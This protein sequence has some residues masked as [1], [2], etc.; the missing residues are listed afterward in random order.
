MG[1]DLRRD[2]FDR[3]EPLRTGERGG[4]TSVLPPD[5]KRPDWSAAT[6]AGGVGCARAA[7]PPLGPPSPAAAAAPKLEAGFCQP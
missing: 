2:R 7:G 5:A 4:G 3:H 1:A 6:G